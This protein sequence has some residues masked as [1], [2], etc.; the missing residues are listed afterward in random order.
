MNPGQLMKVTY[1]MDTKK[2]NKYIKFTSVYHQMLERI[3]ENS[4]YEHDDGVRLF[5]FG[6]FIK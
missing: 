3:L 4:P 6:K 5:W 1:H 2:I